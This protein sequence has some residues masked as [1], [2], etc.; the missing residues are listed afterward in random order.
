MP[1]KLTQGALRPASLVAASMLHLGRAVAPHVGLRGLLSPLSHVDNPWKI[2]GSQLLYWNDP[3]DLTVTRQNS[4]R[5]TPAAVGSPVGSRQS[6]GVL[7]FYMQQPSAS[8]RYVLR[9]ENGCYYDETDGGNDGA[10]SDVELDLR[11]FSQIT[12]FCG[13]TKESDDAP[14]IPMELGTN[15]SVTVG[16]FNIAAPGDLPQG[17]VCGANAGQQTYYELTGFA[18]PVSALV[19]FVMDFTGALRHNELF[20]YLNNVL[21]QTGGGGAGL[22]GTSNFGNLVLYEGRRANSGLPFAGRLYQRGL[23]AGIPTDRQRARLNAFMARKQGI[24]L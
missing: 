23:V 18:S 20:P 8:S 6:K 21:R 19:I 22:A 3:S 12:A 11:A 14:G 9:Q 15:I 10:F 24:H 13:M 7:P 5:T 16:G 2:F 17:L 4:T 1:A